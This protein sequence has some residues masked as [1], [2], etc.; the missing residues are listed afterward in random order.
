MFMRTCICMP[1][2]C[3]LQSLVDCDVDSDAAKDRSHL[4][5]NQTACRY[6]LQLILV[7][8]TKAL[9]LHVCA[10]ADVLLVVISI[11]T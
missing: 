5:Q 3:G 4:Q 6:S 2:T 8:A 9:C 11:V 1:Y 10:D 7:Y